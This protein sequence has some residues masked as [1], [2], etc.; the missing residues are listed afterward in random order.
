MEAQITQG[1]KIPIGKSTE[2][3]NIIQCA[4]M[5]SPLQ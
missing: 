1:G 5:A 4:M 2:K 3:A